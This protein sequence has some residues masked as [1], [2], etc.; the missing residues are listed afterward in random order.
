M[1]VCWLWLTVSSEGK[2]LAEMLRSESVIV[3]SCFSGELTIFTLTVSDFL[4]SVCSRVGASAVG[5][6]SSRPVLCQQGHFHQSGPAPRC[7]GLPAAGRVHVHTEGA[8]QSS[9]SEHHGGD[10]AGHQRRPWQGGK[11]EKTFW[12]NANNFVFVQLKKD[13]ESLMKSGLIH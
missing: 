9:S 1:T 13:M 6:A 10:P 5:G 12:H 8:P 7:S 11:S 4:F 2:T 3:H